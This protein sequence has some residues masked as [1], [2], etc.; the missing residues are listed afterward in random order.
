MSQEEIKE[1]AD[2]LIKN[3]N[4][5]TA[6]FG[7]VEENQNFFLQA[8][9]DGLRLF[10]AELLYASVNDNES[11]IWGINNEWFDSS[12]LEINYI[13]LIDTERNNISGDLPDSKGLQIFQ[14]I[15]CSIVGI[16]MAI[17][18]IVGAIMTVKT[19]VNWL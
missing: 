1:I 8:N 4:E 12:A 3:S 15:G 11:K 7:I 17:F 5:S 13:E 6:F 10:S 16:L 18:I 9:K 14:K 2:K 19:I